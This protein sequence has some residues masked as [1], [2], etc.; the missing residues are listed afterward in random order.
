MPQSN[1][2]VKL[3]NDYL[4]SVRKGYGM[5]QQINV[6]V[7]DVTRDFLTFSVKPFNRVQSFETDRAQRTL[8]FNVRNSLLGQLGD[9]IPCPNFRALYSNESQGIKDREFAGPFYDPLYQEFELGSSVMPVPEVVI[10]SRKR[11]RS[12]FREAWEAID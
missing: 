1:D 10:E 5:C 8:I 3:A 12:R 11:V 9:L 6:A 4:L 7:E 2:L